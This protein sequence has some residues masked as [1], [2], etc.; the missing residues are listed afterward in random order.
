MINT[1]ILGGGFAGIRAA[2]TLKNNKN[3]HVTV[4]DKNSFHTFTPSLYEVAT[5][6]EPQKNVA[7]P[8][9]DI[10]NKSIEFR[11]GSIKKIDTENKKIVLDS[12]RVLLY[13]YLI[14][15]LGSESADFGVPGINEYGI[16]LKT[17]EDAV[18]IKSALKNAKKIVVG[19]GGF[20]GTEIACE[21]ATHKSNLSVTLVQGSPV[22]LKE[23]GGG[24]SN[25]ARK[26]LEE[27]NVHLIL[28]EHI[29]SVTKTFIELEGGRKLSYDI[30]IWTGG[31]K[32]NNLLGK[33]EVNHLC[34]K[35]FSIPTAGRGGIRG[36]RG[37]E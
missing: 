14:F 33:I 12:N 34:P 28:G 37:R 31:V 16:P 21:L 2:L 23:L 20:S 5:S 36:R 26:R 13:D 6:E 7:I 25:L 3:V 10:F 15:A 1:V 35:S 22:L 17:L 4:I 30:F 29:K 9:S 19:G 18:R 32:P 8:Y 27:G 11:Q 24:I